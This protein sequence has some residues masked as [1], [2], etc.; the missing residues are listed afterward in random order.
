MALPTLSTA[1]ARLLPRF[2]AAVKVA[3]FKEIDTRLELSQMQLMVSFIAAVFFML[4]T[5]GPG[6]LT[7]AGIGSS[8]G[9][10]PGLVFL[11]GLFIGTNLVALAV[12]SGLAAIVFSVPY[13]RN[14]LLLA[15]AGYLLYLAFRIAT[16][17]S[18]IRF[19]ESARPPGLMGQDRTGIAPARLARADRASRA[20]G[21]GL[22]GFPQDNARH[23]GAER[24]RLQWT[25]DFAR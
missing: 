5:P 25:D 17:G 10:R 7:T 3:R 2:A 19:I 6:V 1:R 11:I 9:Y 18:Q 23:G 21:R 8:F 16:A 12:V 13:I 15:S 22:P 14:I 20:G 4:I 24:D